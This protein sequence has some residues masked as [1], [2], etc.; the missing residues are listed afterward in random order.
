MPSPS[1]AATTTLSAWCAPRSE[2]IAIERNRALRRRSA[3]GRRPSPARRA[4]PGRAA[5]TP[6]A[7]PCTRPPARGRP[8]AG[9]S[10]SYR[11]SEHGSSHGGP[12]GRKSRYAREHGERA[13][14]S[15][16]ERRP[17]QLV[18]ELDRRVV[19]RAGSPTRRPR[20][21]GR[22][23]AEGRA[24]RPVTDVEGVPPTP[25]KGRRRRAQ[26]RFLEVQPLEPAVAGRNGRS[27]R[28]GWC[29]DGS[30]AAF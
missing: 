6:A 22:A 24:E 26:R 18:A 15:D 3:S 30:Q 7:P 25:E 9:P 19:L 17:R 23:T 11:W 27:G 12:S 2:S 5:R 28:T 29:L 21:R 1:R 14:R 20:C 4:S 8:I 10:E 16:R 13:G